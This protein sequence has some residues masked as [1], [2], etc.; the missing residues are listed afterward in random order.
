MTTSYHITGESGT[1]F[2]EAEC[3]QDY[4][5]DRD[6]EDP[7]D[8]YYPVGAP[9][10]YEIVV[11]DKQTGLSTEEDELPNCILNAAV[12]ASDEQFPL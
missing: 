8:A 7:A 6:A 2:F 11:T 5:F 12:E 9:R 1:H 4:R 10:F 3:E